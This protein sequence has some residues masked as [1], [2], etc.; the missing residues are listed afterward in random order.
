[1]N[2][3]EIVDRTAEPEPWLEG[4][5]IPWNDPDFS[6][7]MLAE[8]LSSDHDMASRRSAAI[9]A[10]VDWI[11]L[12][13]LG[14]QTANILDLGCGPGLY[15]SRLAERGHTCAGIDFA[16]ASID[17]AV[18]TARAGGLNCTYQL[19]DIRTAE[20]GRGFD[21]VMLIYGEYNVFRSSEAQSILAR[22]RRALVSGGRLLLE[23]H[24]SEAIERAG[25]TVPNWRTSQ[26]GLFSDRPHL[27]LDESVWDAER[28]I[29]TERYYVID[30][31]TTE[32]TLY[33]Q[34]IQAYGDDVH[35]AMLH[36]AGFAMDGVYPAL[37]GED[38]GG[39]FYVILATAR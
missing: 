5:K 37:T 1:M 19:A 14:G 27:R 38:D 12:V 9:D 39:D 15:T 33:A 7:R 16:P 21:L 24:T 17:Y 11:E 8:H 26:R 28:R 32:V 31:A 36:D 23:V 29:A 22:A 4:E 35:A 18:E 30:A 13:V 6:R 20:F 25:T 3:Q 10:H 34:S 2:L